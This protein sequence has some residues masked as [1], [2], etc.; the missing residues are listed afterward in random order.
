[1]ELRFYFD[2]S[3]FES[4]SVKFRNQTTFEKMMEL[5]LL[6]LLIFILVTFVLQN[7]FLNSNSILTHIYVS[8]IVIESVFDHF[9]KHFR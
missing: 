6:G 7:V 9:V 8:F 3:G 4:N 2:L 5:P 1:M